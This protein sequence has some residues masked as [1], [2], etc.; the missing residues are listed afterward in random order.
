MSFE[1]IVDKVEDR[2]KSFSTK[3]EI[4]YIQS[5]IV[6]KQKLAILARYSTVFET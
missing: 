6:I 3:A 2:L 1:D 4:T 5:Q